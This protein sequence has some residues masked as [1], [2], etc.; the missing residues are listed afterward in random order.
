MTLKGLNYH[1]GRLKKNFLMQ[2]VA[3]SKILPT[4]VA[5]FLK[6]HIKTCYQNDCCHAETNSSLPAQ[7]FASTA[8][9]AAQSH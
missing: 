2:S 1:F 9:Q 6:C 4:L 7:S 5:G 8:F 3:F